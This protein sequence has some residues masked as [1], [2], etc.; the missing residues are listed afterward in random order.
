M[1]AYPVVG[2]R[3]SAELCQAFIEGAR[4]DRRHN[5]AAVFYGVDASN[6]AAWRECKASGRDWYYIDN[7]YFDAARGRQFRVTRNRLQHSGRGRSDG[8]RFDA[9]GVDIAPMKCEGH[10]VILV[11]QSAAFM[12]HVAGCRSDWLTDVIALLDGVIDPSR[13]CVRPWTRDKLASQRT[14]E[15]DL[16]D[17]WALVTWSSSAAVTAVLAGVPVFSLSPDSAAWDL[18]GASLFNQP[19]RAFP[20]EAERRRWAGVLA[21]NQWTLEEMRSGVAWAA[22]NAPVTSEGDR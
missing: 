20:G 3:K 17:A 18:S 14:L 11:P 16:L 12:Q 1:I 13:L 9:I 22:L 5:D 2:K 4:T 7:S 15:A 10:R 19:L 6:E 21:D 8:R